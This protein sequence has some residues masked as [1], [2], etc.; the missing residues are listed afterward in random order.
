[1]LRVFIFTFLLFFAS[2]VSAGPKK[3]IR[4]ACIDCYSSASLYSLYAKKWLPPDTE[5]EWVLVQTHEYSEGLNVYLNQFPKKSEKIVC[6]TSETNWLDKLTEKL[7]SFGVEHILDGMDEGSYQA[8]R[9]REKMGLPHNSV[10]L[11]EAR[12]KKNAQMEIAEELGIPTLKFT[13]VESAL[14]FIEKFPQEEIVVKL[15]DGVSGVGMSYFSKSDPLLKEKLQAKLDGPIENPFGKEDFYILQPK[16]VGR[17]FFF[18]TFTFEGKTVVTGLSEYHMIEWGGNILYFIDP[19]LSLDSQMAR[20]L[21]P[22]ALE[23]NRKMKVTHGAAHIEFILDELTGKFYLL[24]NNVRIAGAGIPA[25]ESE[26][27]G[28]GQVDLNLLSILDPQRL[29]EEMAK[30]PRKRNQGALIVVIPS[31]NKGNLTKAGIRE[32]EKLATYFRPS[33]AYKLIPNT[34]VS[35]TKDQNTAAVLMH[36]VGNR[37]AVREDILKTIDLIPTLVEN[38]PGQVG[39]AERIADLSKTLKARVKQMNWRVLPR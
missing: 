12:K 25:V 24:E 37:N 16:I 11:R 5:I 9:I 8:T 10:D 13:S 28:I 26:I 18:N 21:K 22:V 39:C 14:Q 6:D 15:N 4:I 2:W 38:S 7:K 29:R 35:E 17:K 31:A 34:P 30:Y 23:I 1:M 32:I 19:F 27:F 36:L 20:K 33:N 3:I